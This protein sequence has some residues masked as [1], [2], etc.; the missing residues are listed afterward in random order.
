MPA[1]PAA[2][3]WATCRLV[4]ADSKH[5]FWHACVYILHHSVVVGCA[6]YRNIRAG[7]LLRKERGQCLLQVGGSSLRRLQTGRGGGPSRPRGGCQPRGGPR[8][9]RLTALDE[10]LRSHAQGGAVDG[11]E[12]QAEPYV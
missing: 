5:K 4:L 12:R 7:Q 9:P 8:L 2:I 10:E 6:S 1:A 3:L 11:G